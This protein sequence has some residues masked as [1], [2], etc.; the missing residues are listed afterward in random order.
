[1]AADVIRNVALA[2]HPDRRSEAV[3]GIQVNVFRE[4]EALKIGYSIS[5]DTARIR[6]PPPRPVRF[7]DDLWRHTCC[8]L[9]VKG[10]GLEEYREF[11]FS[12]SGE[13]AAYA[14]QTYRKRS[15]LD[16]QSMS[17]KISVRTLPVK[18]QVDAAVSVD[19]SNEKL[20]LG[21]SCVIEQDDGSLSYWALKHPPGKPD[22]HH[23]DSFALE[24]DEIRH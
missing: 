12:P 21:I 15:S 14:F 19:S 11:N 24:L 3:R 6:I 8:E 13:W 5:G 23:A 16:L 7:A 9:F 4:E 17:P 20:I 18:L 2:C 22:F 1:L 10:R